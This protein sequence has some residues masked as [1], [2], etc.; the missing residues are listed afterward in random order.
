VFDNMFYNWQVY[1]TVGAPH[2]LTSALAIRPPAGTCLLTARRMHSSQLH[3][4][5]HQL[6]LPALPSSP[7][8]KRC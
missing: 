4:A 5:R 2:T 7:H 3:A 6:P 8:Q 1:D